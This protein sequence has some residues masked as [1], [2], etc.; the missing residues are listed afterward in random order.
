MISE[1]PCALELGML[2]RFEQQMT[3]CRVKGIPLR[4]NCLIVVALLA[5]GATAC[6]K[7]PFSSTPEYFS[8]L[9]DQDIDEVDSPRSWS[10][11][12]VGTLSVA[13]GDD[14]G[15]DALEV[16][17]LDVDVTVI[18]R[19]SR[20]V[21]RQVFKNHTN[22]RTEGTYEFT[23]PAGASLSR[24][25]MN[26]GD[27]MMEGELV[28]REKARMIYEDIVSRK[29]DPALLEWQGNNRFSTQIFPIEAHGTKTVIIA[30]EQL[31]PERGGQVVYDYTLP[32]LTEDLQRSRI[33]KFTFD[34]VSED[35]LELTSR[36]YT[37]EITQNAPGG[38]VTF[39]A[40]NFLPDGPLQFDYKL[41]R[42]AGVVLAR[43]EHGVAQHF[44]AD[45]RVD[46]PQGIRPRKKAVVVVVDTSAGL[47]QRVL[48]KT[49]EAA[50]LLVSS[51]PESTPVRVVTGDF[52][53]RTCSATT[54]DGVL[55]CLDGIAAGGATDLE[56]LFAAGARAAQEVGGAE[57]LLFT[58]GVASVGEMDGSLLRDRAV[59]QFLGSK[60]PVH[61]IAIGASPDAA[62]LA[63]LAAVT[64]G[65]FARIEPDLTAPAIATRVARA[66]TQLVVENL[67]I[68]VIEGKIANLLPARPVAVVDGESIA[69]MGKLETPTATL[70]LRGDAPGGPW[71]KLVRVEKDRAH[72]NSM[73]PSFWARAQIEHLDATGAPRPDV[74]ALS[75]D[76]GV[77]S[78]YTSFLV[79][80]NEKMYRDHQIARG[81]QAKQDAKQGKKTANLEKS[82]EDLAS[83]LA[84]Q[85][86]S[87][88]LEDVVEGESF[89][90]GGLGLKGTGSGGGGVA[91]EPMGLDR[92]EKKSK[93][94]PKIGVSGYGRG[95]TKIGERSARPPKIV[96]GKPMV[97]GSLDKE[98]IRRVVRKHRNQV[99]YCYERELQKN[100]KLAGRV[101][102]RF[103]IVASGNVSH[104]EITSSTLDNQ[105]VER[106]LVNRHRRWR[107]P[108]VRGGGIVT[109]N[110]PY[111]FGAAKGK[112]K[113]DKQQLAELESAD[114][115]KFSSYQQTRLLELYLV[116]QKEDKARA[117]YAE[118]ISKYGADP[119]ELTESIV[120]TEVFAKER[121]QLATERVSAG[122]TD[123]VLAHAILSEHFV[124]TKNS[125]D[126]ITTFGGTELGAVD[127]E[128][129][130]SGHDEYA[131]GTSRAVFV[132]RM[133][134][135]SPRDRLAYLRPLPASDA[136][137]FVHD[138]RFDARRELV[139]TEQGT[140][141]DVWA[142]HE[143]GAR[144]ERWDDVA[145]FVVT[146]CQRGEARPSK[147]EDAAR[148]L[149]GEV[150]SPTKLEELIAGVDGLYAKRLDV[151]RGQRNTDIANAA[152]IQESVEIL[153]SSG[154]EDQAKRLESEL[155][156]FTPHNFSRRALYAQTLASRGELEAACGQY[157]TAVQISPAQ[158]DTFDTMME[159]RR[160]KPE[161]G[162]MLRKCVV[163]GVSK[164][165]VRRAVS[166]VLT[167][168][169]P[170]ADVDMHIREA[171]GEHVWYSSTTSSNGGLLYYDITDGYGPEIYVLGSGPAGRYDVSLVYYRG[172]AKDITGTLTLLRNAGAK[173][174]T[175]EE[176]KFVL[177]EADSDEEI[178][179]AN[180]T[181][182]GDDRAADGTKVNLDAR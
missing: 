46:A 36:R 111:V 103:R 116:L 18:G 172:D 157:A 90:M 55:T 14:G 97:S 78:P 81:Q 91:A 177:P 93:A 11:S 77:M 142:A 85:R 42:T 45:V 167:W 79:L 13:R 92:V 119:L 69:I 43:A 158:R 109:V 151:L 178:S 174:E 130:A 159:M 165:P 66:T 56:A 60:S 1:L 156:E 51:L 24:L 62:G 80:E 173:N 154:R 169:D 118:A 28:E 29:K 72:V 59:E 115:A 34:L 163:D 39:S 121:V 153:R 7:S 144:A 136:P 152:L 63:A 180:F 3:T 70:A 47:G 6:V 101:T 129:Y 160:A 161:A 122:K 50:R 117:W 83:L 75:L 182:T 40:T 132:A 20:T 9:A 135:M 16:V 104:A 35:A 38:R 49:L 171:G 94:K 73:V 23:L 107:F 22:R 57:V 48:D 41:P 114:R 123:D 65:S 168:D 21:V 124:R 5:V 179:I 134:A 125:D 108:E 150:K 141:Q 149:L 8:E 54:R 27:K 98:I 52:S 155:V 99:R 96:T 15:S 131:P 181:L 30:Y 166:L 147:C 128:R 53:T 102:V 2:G 67:T 26:V 133:K 71:E 106:C 126:F 105:S 76:Y 87:N 17:E 74:V 146:V 95:M 127:L 145:D 64:G 176:F 140:E 31:L 32:K 88:Q 100:P 4:A 148:R 12:N 19:T 25:A 33:S 170:E 110:Y 138:L 139:L 162:E 37:P 68:E 137:T 113:T 82:E 175:R 143:D 89:G 58:D 120:A 44:L 164:L 112:P 10:S 86:E 84:D 61:T